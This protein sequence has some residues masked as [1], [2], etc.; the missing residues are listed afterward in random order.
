MTG[1]ARITIPLL[2]S[3][4]PSTGTVVAKLNL[5]R[6]DNW[7]NLGTGEGREL[8]VL[9][10]TL[11]GTLRHEGIRY[12]LY[13]LSRY[14]PLICGRQWSRNSVPTPFRIFGICDL[15]DD[16]VRDSSRTFTSCYRVASTSR[17]G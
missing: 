11:T 12:F 5:G 7:K 13:T 17:F 15:F 16:I 10:A 4:A 6:Q 2:Q 9:S 1:T 8:S 14:H 3:Y